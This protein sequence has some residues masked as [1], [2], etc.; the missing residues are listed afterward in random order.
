RIP[1]AKN[2]APDRPGRAR[3]ESGAWSWQRKRHHAPS[4][5]RSPGGVST[6]SHAILVK[7]F[8]VLGRFEHGNFVQNISTPIRRIAM[9]AV[10]ALMLTAFDRL[11]LGGDKSP[12]S[13]SGPPPAGSAILYT[14][15]GASDAD[16]V[17]SSVVCIP[18][19]DCPD[20][21]GYVPVAV[22]S[23]KAQGYTIT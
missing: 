13:P 5:P 8:K 2:P 4:R 1:S 10:A 9:A 22:R 14:A 6:P 12:T 18:F 16:G 7:G 3:L 21:M 20:G 19:T 11:G 15:I 23:L 17:G